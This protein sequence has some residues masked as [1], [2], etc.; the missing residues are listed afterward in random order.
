V[1]AAL[2]LPN[3][4]AHA[5]PHVWVTYQTIV[6][7]ANGA[8]TGVDHL[9]TFDEMYTAMAIEGLDKNNDGIYDRSELAELAQTNMDGLK[10]FDYF[11]FAKLGTQDVKFGPPA[12]A[13]LEY[14]NGILTLHYHLPL[15][16]PVPMTA[17]GPALTL[18]I[19]D[20][21]FFI[22]FDPA[23]SD[24]IKLAG[25]PPDCSATFNDPLNARSMEDAK[26]LDDPKFQQLGTNAAF[27]MTM[28]KSIVLACKKP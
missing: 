9:W 6:D 24:A 21:S 8:A 13:W 17:N 22:A 23:K 20:P 10:D 2:L 11:T 19:Y 4:A 14:K 3:P 7:F 28:A 26:K 1:A 16:A 12:D 18:S 5:H 15:A 25:A 27:G